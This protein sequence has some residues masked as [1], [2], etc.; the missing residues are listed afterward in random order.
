M[1]ADSRIT[2]YRQL[3]LVLAAT[4]AVVG[5]PTL[6]VLWL[7]TSGTVNSMWVGTALG[8]AASLLLSEG[9]A[10]LWKKRSG[11]EMLFSDLMVWG[12][13]QRRRNER[14]LTAAADLLGLSTGRPKALSG[15]TLTN[16]ER[17]GLLA[18]LTSSLENGDP[19]TN[20]HSRRVARYA[21]TVAKQMGL[22]RAEVAKIRA[23][24]AMHDVGKLETPTEVLHKEGRLT[25]DEYAVV[26][27]H[28]VDGAEMVAT[29]QDRELT[30]MVRHHHERLDGTGYPDGLR[31]EEIPLGARIL[32]VA[33]T[34]DAITSTRPYRRARA[35]KQAL[36]ILAAEA[37]TQLDADAV[38]AFRASYSGTRPL[39]VWTLLLN[40]RPRL[41]PWLGAGMS[42]ANAGAVGNVV[43]TAATVAAVGGAVLS[44]AVVAATETPRDA[45][46]AA[47]ARTTQTRPART[48]ATP[49]LAARVLMPSATPAQAADRAS[50][51]V[52]DHGVSKTPGHAESKGSERTA[53]QPAARRVADAPDST[54]T[55]QGGGDAQTPAPATPPAASPEVTNGNGKA[56]GKVKH[57]GKGNGNSGHGNGNGNSGNGNAYGHDKGK[58]NST[59]APVAA[60]TPPPSNGNSG[61][62]NSGN[63]NGNSGHGNS[64]HGKKDKA[65]DTAEGAVDG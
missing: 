35:H 29:L 14:R 25:D 26:Q 20:G 19:Y 18:Q 55:T 2:P 34:F 30:A 9:G 56:K 63:G 22:P 47:P 41:A 50:R 46:A 42:P 36:D 7:R 17:L 64:G 43:A 13:L 27:R 58:G 5:L 57:E 39:A 4:F 65:T 33:D 23:A 38:R 24:G 16:E 44:P 37:G 1:E 31:G 53:T 21:A 62:G 3:P 52:T 40:A 11:S 61:N 12:W 10:A 60:P 15:G 8:V 49:A 51:G 32:A 48:S 59:P 45:Q 28:P 6:L 54:T